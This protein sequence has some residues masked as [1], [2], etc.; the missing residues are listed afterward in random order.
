M[1]PALRLG[2]AFLALFLISGGAFVG[3]RYYLS[4]QPSQRTVAR[5]KGDAK[6]STASNKTQLPAP[7]PDRPAPAPAADKA[8]AVPAPD[9]GPAM[10]RTAPARDP[11]QER[12]IRLYGGM[13]P[14][15]AAAVMG[16]LDPA[17]SVTILSGLPERQA[18]KILGQLPPKTAAD[19]VTRMNQGKP[20]A[21]STAPAAK[22]RVGEKS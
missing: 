9:K 7:A 4:P 20:Q 19:L 10:E 3:W 2:L 5:G 18:A 14:R 11:D 1:R 16:Q 22:P 17:L 8:A 15:E 13:R 6:P 21:A 12:L